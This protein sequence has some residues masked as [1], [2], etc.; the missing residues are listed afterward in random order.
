MIEQRY[1]QLVLTQKVLELISTGYAEPLIVSATGSGKTVMMGML[2]SNILTTYNLRRVTVVVPY[3]DLINQTKAALLRFN[4]NATVVT[5]QSAIKSGDT[6]VLIFDEAQHAVSQTGYNIVNSIGYHFLLGF[7]ATPYRSDDKGL[8][9]EN[10]G[11]FDSLVIGPSPEEL[12][13][14]G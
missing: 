1:Y 3:T 5:Y 2:L 14:K 9:K 4:I 12:T 11:I 6:D 10:N 7:T 8:L 13:N